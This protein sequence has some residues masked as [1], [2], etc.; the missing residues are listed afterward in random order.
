M[1]AS[2][3]VVYIW[4]LCGIILHHGHGEADTQREAES[5]VLNVKPRGLSSFI[6]EIFLTPCF[7]LLLR[8]AICLALG[9][10]EIVI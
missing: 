2:T 3:A 7:S 1:F 6:Y 4:E 8:P 5:R 10:C 9:L